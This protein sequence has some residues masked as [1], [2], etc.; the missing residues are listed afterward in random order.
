MCVMCKTKHD[1]K[2]GK[3]R[4]LILVVGVRQADGG[5]GLGLL[6]NTDLQ[7]HYNKRAGDLDMAHNTTRHNGKQSA[8][9]AKHASDLL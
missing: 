8:G 9:E 7:M 5:L 1:A 3:A 6:Y 2:D 4:E